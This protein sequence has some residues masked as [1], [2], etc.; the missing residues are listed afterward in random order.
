MGKAHSDNYDRVFCDKELGNLK[1][2]EDH[3]QQKKSNNNFVLCLYF[4]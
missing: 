4:Y 2:L 3:Q 1:N